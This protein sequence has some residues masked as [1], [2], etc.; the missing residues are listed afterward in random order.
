MPVRLCS[1]VEVAAAAKIIGVK[2][3]KR[4]SHV[5]A[6]STAGLSSQVRVRAAAWDESE[7]SW[8]FVSDDNSPI[9]IAWR[10][11]VRAYTAHD[12][13]RPSSIG[14]L[15]IHSVPALLPFSGIEEIRFDDYVVVF[16]LAA[17]IDPV[18]VMFRDR[19]EL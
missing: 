2:P 5:V 16:P 4:I 9:T 8:I 3:F 14:H 17:G 15:S 12:P 13:D 1:L 10:G 7:Q 11:D 19:R 6:T 18:Y